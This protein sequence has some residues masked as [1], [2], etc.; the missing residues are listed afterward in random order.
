MHVAAKHQVFILYFLASFACSLVYSLPYCPTVS[1]AVPLP[2]PPSPFTAY[3]ST[4]LP[5]TLTTPLLQYMTNFTTTLLSFACGRD[6]YSPLVTCADCQNA[7]RTWLCT[8][9]F[10]RCS[11]PSPGSPISSSIPA[12]SATGLSA[13]VQPGNA[14]QQIPISALVPQPTSAVPRN[15]NLPNMTTSYLS[16][17]PCLEVCRAVDR[18]C[19]SFLGF[20][21]PKLRFNAAA[22]YGV[23]YVDEGRDGIQ[24]NGLT[25]VTQD[26]WGN[27][28]CNGA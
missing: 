28:W 23:G 15:S 17:L 2:P 3:D 16:L 8:I 7:Y 20:K 27:V 9:S 4:L 12:A 11:E 5:S 13:S 14:G 1:Y 24:G 25:G 22:S 26:Q 6:L 21:C 18:A 10:T 19:P